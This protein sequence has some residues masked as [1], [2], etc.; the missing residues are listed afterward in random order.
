[1]DRSLWIRLAR[2]ILLPLRR[3]ILLTLAPIPESKEFKTLYPFLVVSLGVLAAFHTDRARTLVYFIAFS[4]I[5]SI[6]LITIVLD[7]QKI[8]LDARWNLLFFSYYRPSLITLTNK[9]A[10]SIDGQQKID[11]LTYRTGD[12]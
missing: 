10:R 9:I 11:I 7:S 3:F 2:S 6:S 1:M 12:F 5:A 4:L 8:K